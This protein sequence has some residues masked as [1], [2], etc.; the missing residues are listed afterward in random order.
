[1]VQKMQEIRATL[2]ELGFEC[3]PGKGSHEVWTDPA[4]P[5][6]RVVLTGRDGDDAHRY[7]ATQVR[8]CKRGMMVSRHRKAGD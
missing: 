3:R 5:G 6:R 7:Q 4:L 1:M 2:R 8:R